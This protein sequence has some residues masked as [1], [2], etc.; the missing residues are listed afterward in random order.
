MKQVDDFPD[1]F[2]FIS[3]V[4]HAPYKDCKIYQNDQTKQLIAVMTMNKFP[5]EI[6]EFR[7][8][9]NNVVQFINWSKEDHHLCGDSHTVSLYYE[10]C[11]SNLE[12]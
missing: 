10:Y 3:I 8:V 5:N 2:T 1:G 7:G 9:S 6:L 11:P 12:M 4:N